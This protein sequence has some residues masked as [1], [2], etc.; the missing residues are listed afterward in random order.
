MYTAAGTWLGSHG[1]LTAEQ[2]ASTLAAQALLKP[3]DG[4]EVGVCLLRVAGA[5]PAVSLL[6][7]LLPWLMLVALAPLPRRRTPSPLRLARPYLP[8]AQVLKAFLTARQAY[9]MQCLSAATGA[10][11]DTDLESLACILADVAT[12]VCATLAQAGELFI[13]LPGVSATP[14]LAAALGAEDATSA[15]L[16][17]DTP[18]REAEA[19]RVRRPPWPPA[20]RPAGLP[21]ACVAGT[22]PHPACHGLLSPP[23][24]RA[25]WRRCGA[26]CLS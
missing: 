6:L 26:G 22:L 13:Q 5:V 25:T 17:F 14:L 16:I 11:A 18:G 10:G 8:P 21:C 7:R 1:E 12:T 9:V 2:A 24:L 20:C 4:A 19:W 15:D 3:M 23:E